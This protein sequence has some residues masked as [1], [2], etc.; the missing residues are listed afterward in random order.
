ML[1]IRDMDRS[2]TKAGLFFGGAAIGAL[3]SR[4]V[5]WRVTRKKSAEELLLNSLQVSE[6]KW[7]KEGL[8]ESRNSTERRP[9]KE[10]AGHGR[11]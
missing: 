3:L 1:C 4:L 7:E 9:K 6:T 8:I 11:R 5:F 10:L 2:Q